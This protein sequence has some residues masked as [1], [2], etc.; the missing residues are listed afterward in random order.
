MPGPNGTLVMGLLPG[1]IHRAVTRL[2]LVRCPIA[3]VLVANS[4]LL[5]ETGMVKILFVRAFV[6]YGDP[7]SVISAHVM[8]DTRSLTAPNARAGLPPPTLMTPLQGIRLSPTRVRK[9]P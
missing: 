5:R 6:S 9:L 1:L 7:M 4:F 3:L 2:P 8:E